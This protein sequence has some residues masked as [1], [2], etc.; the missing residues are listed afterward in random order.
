MS[1]LE[2]KLAKRKEDPWGDG[3]LW[4][5][6]LRDLERGTFKRQPPPRFPV[7]ITPDSPISSA[8]KLQQLTESESLPEVFETA[9]LEWNDE[10]TGRRV[11]VGDVSR[12]EIKRLEEKAVVNDITEEI[13]VMFYGVTRTARLVKVLRE[14]VS[15]DASEGA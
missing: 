3:T 14:G 5:Q 13:Y 8:E 6:A 15:V 1:A 2:Q 7:I 11:T 10:D 4:A 12:E 9:L